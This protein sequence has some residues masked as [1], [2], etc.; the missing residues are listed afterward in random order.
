MHGWVLSLG[1]HGASMAAILAHTRTL[2]TAA[3]NWELYALET[4]E[5]LADIVVGGWVNGAA[6]GISKKLVERIVG[7]AL[8][9]LVVIVKLLAL[10][11]G[12]VHRTIGRVLGRTS[13]EAC[14]STAWVLLAIAS[15]GTETAIWILISTG[16]SGKCLQVSDKFTVL[17]WVALGSMGT[18]TVG[19]RRAEQDRVIGMC[20]D[21]LFQ[22][23][24]AFKGLAT[25]V[26]LVRLQ[27]HVNANVRCNVVTLYRSGAAVAPL[28]GKVQVVG[29]LAAH[30]TLTN[31]VVE[32]LSGGQTLTAALPLAHE[33]V[34]RASRNR[35]RRI[36]LCWSALGLLL[37]R[38]G[39]CGQSSIRIAHSWRTQR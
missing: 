21:M 26:A 3:E 9:N 16:C 7:C 22:I 33:L 14:R 31:M 38:G 11:D 27:W 36:L 25:E 28:A 1:N 10:I 24:G 5:S 8:S 6:L 12:I 29:A 19:L 34:S 35:R 30:M 18:A 4:H 15:I 13:I 39:R 23:L 32:L 17:T 37:R 20:L 2:V